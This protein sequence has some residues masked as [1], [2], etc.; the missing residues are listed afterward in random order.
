MP[1]HKPDISAD[2]VN[3]LDEIWLFIAKDSFRNA[4]RVIDELY[5]AMYDLAANP[6]MGHTRED[7]TPGEMKFWSVYHYMIIDRKSVV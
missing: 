3:D 1:L 2:A 6:G 5:D 4:D 7:L